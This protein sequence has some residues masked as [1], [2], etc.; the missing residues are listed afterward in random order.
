[1]DSRL[2]TSGIILSVGPSCRQTWVRLLTPEKGQAVHHIRCHP[3]PLRGCIPRRLDGSALQWS[4]YA[5]YHP[6]FQYLLLSL[7]PPQNAP[8]PRSLRPGCPRI[9]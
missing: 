5:Q 7:R 1:M 4:K 8:T 2:L 9:W 6:R 3:R